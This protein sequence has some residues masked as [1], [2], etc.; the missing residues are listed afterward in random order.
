M[1]TSEQVQ[2]ALSKRLVAI[3]G[4]QVLSGT[5]GEVPVQGNQLIEAAEDFLVQGAA[6]VRTADAFLQQ[7]ATNTAGAYK[8]AVNAK[9]MA[10]LASELA[11]DAEQDASTAQIL[12]TLC[13][14][15]DLIGRARRCDGQGLRSQCNSLITRADTIIDAVLAERRKTAVLVS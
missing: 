8:L 12:G 11:R 4:D 7:C 13:W 2:G 3:V 10:R 1:E 9:R 6:L 15:Q 5:P 14:D